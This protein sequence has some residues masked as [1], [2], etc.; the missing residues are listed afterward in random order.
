LYG[1]FY[2]IGVLLAYK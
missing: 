2:V 1:T